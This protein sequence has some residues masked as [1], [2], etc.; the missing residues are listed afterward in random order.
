MPSG[1]YIDVPIVTDPD[2]LMADALD[3]MAAAFP[4]WV[5]REGHLE[6]QLIEVVARIASIQADVA[7]RIPKSVFRYFGKNLVGLPPVD[8]AYATVQSTWVMVDTQGY[9][10][11]AGTVVAFSVAGDELVPFVTLEDFVVSPGGTTTAA[12]SV[13]LQATEPG[14]DANGLTG[15]MQLVDA[16]A[17]VSSITATT[18]SSGGVDAETDDEYLARLAAELELLAPRP[19]LP[20]DFAVL[21]RRVT[22]VHRA[23]AIDG[24][25][26]TGPTTDNER[27]VTIV[28]VDEDGAAV[29]GGVQTE[30]ETYLESLREIN[31][32]VHTDDPTYTAITVV[33]TVKMVA[34]YTA[35]DVEDRIEA[36]VLAYLSPAYWG[37]G[38]ETPPAWNSGTDVVRYLEIASIINAV[39]G[40]DYITTLTVNGG[41]SN[42]TMTG[43]A[44]LPDPA[45]TCTATAT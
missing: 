41:T 24:Y 30:I 27:M 38:T 36:A 45:S 6:V 10:V 4:G 28:A 25:D 29:S 1:G 18:T 3:E 20:Q 12:G 2:Q 39:D 11:P 9:T 15:S 7:S 16:L 14:S 26:P 43:I 19:I 44:P 33:T 35:S 40:V 31:F 13:A 5:P 42:V 32:V 22:G 17:Y 23:V 8:A 37:G 21:A 34:G